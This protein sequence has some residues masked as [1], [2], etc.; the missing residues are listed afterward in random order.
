MPILLALAAATACPAPIVHDGDT[1]RCNGDR[2]RLIDIDAPELTGSPRCAPERV[3]ELA[4]TR[5]PSW[6]DDLLAQ[7][8]RNALAEFLAR[9]P[10]LVRGVARDRYGRLLAYVSVAGQDAGAYLVGAGLA[11]WWR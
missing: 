2:V 9:G 8:A 11:R 1:I 3:A 5:D 7:K 4:H 10:V 6:C